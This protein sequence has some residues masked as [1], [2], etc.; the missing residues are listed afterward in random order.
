MTGN[1]A[2][3]T[4]L[5]LILLIATGGTLG[6]FVYTT[7]LHKKPFMDDQI[8]K[9]NLLE[10]SKKVVFVTPYKFDKMTV[11]LKSKR[12]TRLRYLDVEMHFVPFS[13][14]ISEKMDLMKAEIK[15]II[16]DITG[17][18]KPNEINTVSGKII[19]ES[20]L[21]KAVNKIAKKKIIKKILFSRFV[22][23]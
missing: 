18:M 10:D 3:D 20:R 23:Q 7:V 6:M 9:N 1:K 12:S 2:I 16:I 19:Y 21:K 13:G 22:V 15:D 14:E 11:N 4:I 8:E 17:H 5:I